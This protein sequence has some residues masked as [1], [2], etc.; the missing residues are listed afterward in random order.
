LKEKL[1]LILDFLKQIFMNA[2][3]EDSPS[4]G[5]FLKWI[6]IAILLVGGVIANGYFASQPMVIRLI[7]WVALVALAIF[8][9]FQT[10]QG[11]KAWE[12]FLDARTELRKVTW[13][14]RQETIQTTTLVVVMVGVAALFLWG[15]DTLLLWLVSLF[16]R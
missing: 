10:A 15:V 9:A 7:G 11:R 13:P 6:T 14:T 16:T 5:D 3:V 1:K 8:I 12:F 2:K 4:T